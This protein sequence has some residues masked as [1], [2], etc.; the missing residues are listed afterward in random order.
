MRLLSIALAAAAP[1]LLAAT[2]LAGGIRD[3]EE[4][5]WGILSS[6]LHVR[7]LA[8]GTLPS[9]T[10]ALGFG[11]P[12]PMVPNFN[13]HP[14]VPLLG[15]VSPVA[16]VRL[17]YAGHTIVGATGVWWLCRA[18]P[19][20]PVVRGVAVL[21]YLLATPTSNYALTDVWPSHY[22]MWTSA[23]WLLLL[24]WRLLAAAGREAARTAVLLGLAGGVA[25]ATTHP[26]H[27][28]VY[29]TVVLAVAAARVEALK[30]RAGWVALAVCIALA[31]ASPNLVQLA[32]EQ[33]VFDDELA[34]VKFPEPLPP[35]SAPDVFLKPLSDGWKPE[36]AP[37]E[38]RGVFFGG[39]FAVLALVGLVWLGRQHA[40]LAIGAVLSAG[41]LFT[42]L[43]P[44]TFLSRY[45]FRDPALLCA[46][47]LAAVTADALLRRRRGRAVAAALL[48]LQCAAV[49]LAVMPFL[50]PLWGAGL[51]QAALARGAT[52]ATVVVDRLLSATAAPGRMAY[53]PQVDYEI[54]ERGWLP[55]G[56][57]VNALA[58][59]GLS[60]VNGS[61]KAVS[62]D[63]LWPDE[64]LFYGRV[65]LPEPLVADD[66][67][68]DRLGVRYLVA[69]RGETVARGLREVGPLTAGADGLLL[70]E[71]PDA[72]PGAFLVEG[73][74]ET[75]PDLP[76]YA[77][78]SNDRLLCRDLTPLARL[79]AGGEVRVTRRD[80][81]I[82]IAVAGAPAPRLL[83]V[84]EMYR[85][86]WTAA[87]TD[88]PLPVVPVGPGLIGVV[89]P[90]GTSA[91]RLE[92]RSPWLTSATLLAWSVLAAGLAALVPLS[93]RRAPDIGALE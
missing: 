17:L 26:G 48:A 4:F 59:R 55:L 66:T 60:I 22:V 18:L 61:F 70:Y 37:G 51:R 14:L 15:L 7:A 87:G 25:L 33:R 53:A 16:W 76:V 65:R 91:I 75:L 34:I 29:G 72:G 47:P 3:E 63:V 73:M 28:P 31:V 10:S 78:C 8:G 20:T 23:P 52:A 2:F 45:Q 92:H 44:L 11:I 56:F 93:R 38:A 40:D 62:T 86:A 82:D 19:V 9:W 83:V 84:V 43:L 39:P 27:A 81:R 46:I 30:A 1:A 77:D 32:S 5:R 35:S 41:L 12:Q 24:A 64:R 90:G 74:P 85:P 88:G 50:R 13:L 79:G 54:S 6:Y 68:L 69:K 21:T 89:V 80:G 36:V 49:V 57:G 58:Y 71:N 42:P 67:A